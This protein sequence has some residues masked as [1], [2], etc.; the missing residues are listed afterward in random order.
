[1]PHLVL[2]GNRDQSVGR[3]E[4]PNPIGRADAESVVRLFRQV[5][6]DEYPFKLFY[7]QDKLARANEQ[8]DYYTIVARSKSGEI[9]GIHNLFRSAPIRDVY[10][11]GYLEWTPAWLVRDSPAQRIGEFLGQRG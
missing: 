11:W 2:T 7:D 1:L 6:G 10:E 8:G 4:S 9:V 5:Y 3:G